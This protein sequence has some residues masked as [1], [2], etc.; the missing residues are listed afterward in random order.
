MT[1]HVLNGFVDE[2]VKTA[3]VPGAGVLRRIAESPV[4]ENRV[5]RT[6]KG[7]AHRAGHDPEYRKAL[8]NAALFGAGQNAFMGMFLG[9]KNESRTRRAV[10]GGI[11]GALEGGAMA[12]AFPR[13]FMPHG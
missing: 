13:M 10:K 4:A 8:K 6:L 9:D 2:L 12:A 1:P 3:A 11:G 7:L 5:G